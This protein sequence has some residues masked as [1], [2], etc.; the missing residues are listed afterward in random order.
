MPRALTVILAVVVLASGAVLSGP[1]LTHGILSAS[2]AVWEGAVSLA[3]V[4]AGIDL[5]ALE[6]AADLLPWNSDGRA[7]RA[8]NAYLDA[9]RLS[10]RIAG[11]VLGMPLAGLGLLAAW[12]FVRGWRGARAQRTS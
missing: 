4:C 12:R 10:E 8:R 11:A 3:A 6:R 7:S 5:V 2:V 9:R 1:P